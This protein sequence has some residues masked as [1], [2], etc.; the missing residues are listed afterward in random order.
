MPDFD[1]CGIQFALGWFSYSKVIDHDK[2]ETYKSIW[3]VWDTTKIWPTY[4][5]WG[6]SQE[7]KKLFVFLDSK[8]D[9]VDH[10]LL[11]AGWIGLVIGLVSWCI[12]GPQKNVVIQ[13]LT[14]R[15]HNSG[16]IQ[17]AY[18]DFGTRFNTECPFL[19]NLHISSRLWTGTQG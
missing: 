16:P 13:L 9:S 10:H 6:I 12:M 11:M 2:K 3:T 5:K 15:C 17:S 8:I 7:E 19:C 18:F 1:I 14:L 4:G